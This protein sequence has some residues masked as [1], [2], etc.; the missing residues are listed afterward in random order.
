MVTLA[1]ATYRVAFVEAG[2]P[3]GTGWSVTL[4]GRYE[5]ANSSEIWFAE[6][7]GSYT[8]SVG[9]MRGW[10]A[11]NSTGTIRVNGAAVYE[12]IAWSQVTYAVTFLETGLPGGTEWWVS[13]LD[14]PPNATI[15]EG[16]SV[17]Y[18]NGTYSY[19]L[20]TYDGAYSAPGGSFMVEGAP[21]ELGARFTAISCE[22]EFTESGLPSGTSW[23]VALNGSMK[24]GTGDIAFLGVLVGTYTFS[25]TPVPGYTADPENGSIVVDGAPLTQPILFSA[26]TPAPGNAPGASAGE[27]SP[28]GGDASI[29]AVIAVIAVG[30]M[31]MILPRRRDEGPPTGPIS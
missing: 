2:L 27:L 10:V 19:T 9:A 18:P 22:L 8:Y 7:D 11:L 4:G 1:A 5:Q 20:G 29:A 25:V 6:P 14:N 24:A 16:L 31:L 17:R 23:S 12:Y 15:G 30:A 3:A 21:V 26:G 13:V 28:L